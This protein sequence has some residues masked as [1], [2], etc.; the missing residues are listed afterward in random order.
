M[1]VGLSGCVHWGVFFGNTVAQIFVSIFWHH[2]LFYLESWHTGVHGCSR[3][4]ISMCAAVSCCSY[5]VLSPEKERALCGSL[6]G[7][8]LR[9]RP[10]STENQLSLATNLDHHLLWKVVWIVKGSSAASW[11]LKCVMWFVALACPIIVPY[12][13]NGNVVCGSDWLKKYRKIFELYPN[14][15]LTHLCNMKEPFILFYTLAHN[16][17]V[18][19]TG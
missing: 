3:P 15:T 5:A 18:P 9:T 19:I 10:A 12:F 8:F 1:S 2:F 7:M 13:E 16:W 17:S 4:N 14:F 6:V 11:K